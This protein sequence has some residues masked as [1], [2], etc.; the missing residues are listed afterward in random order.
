MSDVAVAYE[1]DG[2]EPEEIVLL[3]PGLSL[4]DVHRAL[5]FYYDHR[6]T[7]ETIHRRRETDG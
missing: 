4:A 1:H 6:E 3:Y 7:F 5:A 2:Y